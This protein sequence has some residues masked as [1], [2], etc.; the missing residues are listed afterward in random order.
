MIGGGNILLSIAA[1]KAL[2]LIWALLLI[3]VS[4]R[5]AK[6]LKTS[7]KPLMFIV[8]NPVFLL[9]G[10][11]QLHC[12]MLA[13]TLCLCMLYFYFQ[14]RW[15]LAFLFAGLAICAKMSFVI[16]LGFIVVAIF[17]ERETWLSFIY[18]TVGGLCITFVTV[19]VLYYPSYTS[20]DTFRVPFNF[21]FKQNPAKSIAEV[22][23]DI[24]YF[25][26]SV[27]SGHNDE[28]NATMAKSNGVSDPQLAVWT[29]VKKACQ[30]FAFL[31]S[32]FIFIRYWFGKRESQ[33]WMNIYLRF[34]LI[35]LL[36]YSHVFYAWYLMI[37]LPFVWYETD[38]RFM[39]WL[40]VLTSFSNVHDIMCAVNRG[41]P[42]YFMVLPLTLFSVLVFFWRFRNNFFTSLKYAPTEAA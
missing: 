35:F 22:I 21:L 2:A 24:V 42:V 9:Q 14:R 30:I 19:F 3:E 29:G 6:L 34:V 20:P 23:G 12:D 25:A 41:T 1:Y 37:L 26:P 38:I 28:L 39:Q 8:L 5:I 36:F 27:I 16:I 32:G 13:I 18:K 11:G 4:F 10:V 31:L 17:L 7:V 33:Q 40:F 15:H